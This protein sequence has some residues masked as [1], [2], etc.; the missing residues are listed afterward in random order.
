MDYK[1]QQLWKL[2][3]CPSTVQRAK[4]VDPLMNYCLTMRMN[5]NAM[6]LTSDAEWTKSTL[7]E[8]FEIHLDKE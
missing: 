7:Q 5:N 8:Y 4:T 2:P 1:T 3:K 6:N